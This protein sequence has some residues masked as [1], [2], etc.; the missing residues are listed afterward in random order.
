MNT[1]MPTIVIA[2]TL[3]EPLLAQSPET[4]QDE[5]AVYDLRSTTCGR[6]IPRRFA[7]STTW[8]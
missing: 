3:A 1:R 6:L 5:Y 7:Q 2:F 4:L 8:L